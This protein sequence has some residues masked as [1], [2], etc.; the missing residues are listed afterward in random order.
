[1]RTII[2]GKSRQY[3]TSISDEDYAYLTQWLWTFAVSHRGGGLIYIRRSIRVGDY[4]K[5][6]LMHRVILERAVGAPP[7]DRHTCDHLDGDTFNN[8]RYNLEWATHSEQMRR[9]RILCKRPLDTLAAIP[10]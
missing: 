1:M 6:I 3:V 4:N 9:R 2:C 5:T 7:S 8:Q 10:F